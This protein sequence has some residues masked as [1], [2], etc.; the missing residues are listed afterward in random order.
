M[1]TIS[2]ISYNFLYCVIFVVV[3]VVVVV[4]C[5]FLLLFST[6]NIIRFDNEAERFMYYFRSR[7]LDKGA[8]DTSH[9]HHSRKL[10]RQVQDSLSVLSEMEKRGVEI[11]GHCLAVCNTTLIPYLYHPYTMFI[12]YSYVY[13]LYTLPTYFLYS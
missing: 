10:N 12:T 2:H 9:N 1:F 7:Q 3:V 13:L 6:H 4:F 11:D 5:C 8:Q